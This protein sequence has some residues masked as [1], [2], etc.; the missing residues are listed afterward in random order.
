MAPAPVWRSIMMLLESQSANI[1]RLSIMYPAGELFPRRMATVLRVNNIQQLRC[2]PL[3][4]V[5]AACL[6][7]PFR[8]SGS[9][10]ITPWSGRI[11]S[12]ARERL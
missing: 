6:I 8:N 10:H 7:L 11:E 12:K 9:R 1:G 4:R 3:G 5:L 2:T